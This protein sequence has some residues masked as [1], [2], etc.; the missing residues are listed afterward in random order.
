MRKLLLAALCAVVLWPP[1]LAN[2]Q[3][4]PS[5]PIR[6]VISFGPGS[7]S[8]AISR[9]LANELTK[10][11]GQPV[12]IIHKPGADG[13][14]SGVEVQRSAPD[15]YTFLFGTNS[16]LAVAPNL[17][18]APPYN[19]LTDFTPVGMV[20]L[21]TL[22]F[23]VN[24]SLPAKTMSE[25]VA[26]IRANPGKLNAATGHT[27]AIVSTGLFARQH[28]LQLETVPYKGEPDAIVDLLAS[29]VHM[30]VSTSTAVYGH[31]KEG[32]LRVLAGS[33]DVRNPLWPDV[34][35]LVEAG[36]APHPFAAFFAVVGPA[37]L[38]AEIAERMNK[39]IAAAIAK[40]EARE[41]MKNQG[42]IAQSMSIPEFAAYLKSQNVTWKKALDESGVQPN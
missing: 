13:T 14:I 6:L 24:P 37:G 19:V 27:Y 4:W 15:G 23:V 16:A 8:D 36:Q 10:Q 2:A 26:H 20:G 3:N 28:G 41:Q 42:V 38:P 17:R 34:P 9:I 21:N 11:L 18:K 35:T 1:A 25:L 5:K 22:F 29:R 32:K 39:E 33:T 31:A 40:P 7:A 30:M 12:V